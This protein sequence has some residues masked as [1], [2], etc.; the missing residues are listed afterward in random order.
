MYYDIRY[1]ECWLFLYGSLT[2][3]GTILRGVE[4]VNMEEQEMQ[5]IIG[6]QYYFSSFK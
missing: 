3:R 1:R 5:H 6:S 4:A 2:I